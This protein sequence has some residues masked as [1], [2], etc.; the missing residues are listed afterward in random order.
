[1]SAPT[2][3]AEAARVLEDVPDAEIDILRRVAKALRGL[4]TEAE[5]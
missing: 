5:S 1:M 3:L 4:D 2:T